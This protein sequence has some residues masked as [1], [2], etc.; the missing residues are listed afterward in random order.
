MTLNFPALAVTFGLVATIGCP[1]S[2]ET[3]GYGAL[4]QW[5]K[6]DHPILYLETKPEQV[7]DIH[8]IGPACYSITVTEAPARAKE[9]DYHVKAR[10]TD[11]N[12][13][14]LSVDRRDA[15]TIYE[16][17]SADYLQILREG[18][19]KIR[20]DVEEAATMRSAQILGPVFFGEDAPRL[21]AANLSGSH[22]HRVQ[23]L[24]VRDSEPKN[25]VRSPGGP[26]LV[27]SYEEV[28]PPR[29]IRCVRPMFTEEEALLAI[30]SAVPDR[31]AR[32][33]ASADKDIAASL[34]IFDPRGSLKL[35]LS[36]GR[37]DQ[38]AEGFFPAPKRA[39]AILG[40]V[41]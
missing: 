7:Q 13:W 29:S 22:T 37:R 39:D 1:S 33:D 2:K 32:A 12:G 30:V 28:M 11:A 23:F 34:Q 19:A 8:D 16:G 26:S 4:M 36:S 5:A 20:E 38:A 3:P 27:S 14:D 40:E 17:Q 25:F 6:D 10:W 15:V 9:A 24:I 41:P 18:C 31:G 35:V 21:C